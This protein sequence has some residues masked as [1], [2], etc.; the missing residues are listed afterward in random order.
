MN[1]TEKAEAALA[2]QAMYRG[3]M[4]RRDAEKEKRL[5]V[6]LNKKRDIRA[7]KKI[8][9]TWRMYAAKKL[10]RKERNRKA[11]EDRYRGKEGE[12]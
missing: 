6:I 11:R 5:Q 2:I 12:E 9:K 1:S 7:A 4:G 10:A 8:Q 3:Y